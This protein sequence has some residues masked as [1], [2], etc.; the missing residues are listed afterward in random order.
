MNTLDEWKAFAEMN[1]KNNLVRMVRHTGT[2]YE[3]YDQQKIITLC[4][5][6]EKKDEA[7]KKIFDLMDR[8]IIIRE[9]IDDG[10][11]EWAKNACEVGFAIYAAMQALETTEELK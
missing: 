1:L 6:V 4:E 9:T 5:L 8:G 11:S 10:S 3:K 7:L 2:D